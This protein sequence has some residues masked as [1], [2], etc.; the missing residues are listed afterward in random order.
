ML[1][2]RQSRKA[3]KPTIVMLHGSGSSAAIFGIQTHMLAKDLSSTYDLVYLDGPMLSSP[4]PGVLPLFADM[5]SYHRW[6]SSANSN[7]SQAYRLAELFEVARHIQEQL[8]AQ[9][10][11]PEQVVAFLGFSQGALVALALLGLRSAGQSAWTNLRFCVAIAGGTTGDAGQ[12][13]NI[14]RLVGML[15]SIVGRGDAKFPGFTVHAMGS[16]DLWYADGQR[17]ASMCPEDKTQKMTYREGHVVPRKRKDVSQLIDMISKVDHL[18]AHAGHAEQTT[19][20]Q[21]MPS[22]LNGADVTE[23]LAFLSSNGIQ[24]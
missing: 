18:G 23:G 3:K 15:S 4:G 2:N 9:Q 13:D 7:L 22:L 12:L 11:D 24:V 8:E 1:R 17:L 16:Q 19:I 10:V 20:M 14:E 6:I 5:P 21:S